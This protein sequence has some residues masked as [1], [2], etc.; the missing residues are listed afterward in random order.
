VSV[1]VPTGPASVRRPLTGLAVAD[2]IST[3]GTEMTAVALPWFVLVTTGSPARM[4]VVLAAEFAGL[5]LLGLIGGRVATALGPRRLMLSSDLGRAGLI[6]LIPV[7]S[8]FSALSFPVILAIGFVIGG[9]FPAYQSA[10]RILLADLVA[11]DELRMT[12]V[13]GLLNAV[14][15][16]ASFIGP[17]LGGTLVAVFGAGPVLLLDAVSYLAAF[18]LVGLLVRTPGSG[19]P[20]DPAQNSIVEGLRYLWRHRRLRTVVAGIALLEIGFTALVATLPVLALHHG[21]ASVAGWLLGAYGGGSVLG[22]LISSRARRTGGR[23]AVL[24]VCGLAGCT[25]VLVAPIPVWFW[26]LAI[27]GTGVASGLFF[28]RFFSELTTTTPPA[29]RARVLTAA[30]IVMSAPGPIGFI[31]AGL[32]ATHTTLGSRLLIAGSA[33]LGAVVIS[34]AAAPADSAHESGAPEGSREP[35]QLTGDYAAGP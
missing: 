26:G 29:L 6:A 17:A 22:G 35:H 18:A 23:T 13:G 1:D 34:L 27:G 19:P 15:E 24:A 2:I 9:F 14:N 30:T 16:S 4:G 33:T 3:T 10:G 21:G 20:A 12:R 11:D 31:G 28:P 7:L 8:Y 25:W 5:T 32:L